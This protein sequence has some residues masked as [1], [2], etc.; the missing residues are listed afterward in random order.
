MSRINSGFSWTTPMTP[1]VPRL[2][3][4]SPAFTAPPRSA[5]QHQSH[6]TDRKARHQA[7]FF[8]GPFRGRPNELFTGEEVRH[9]FRIK[10][11]LRKEFFIELVLSKIIRDAKERARREICGRLPSEL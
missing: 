2:I 3:W 5:G 7:C 9:D 4:M 10:T 6:P 1:H 8:G 11:N